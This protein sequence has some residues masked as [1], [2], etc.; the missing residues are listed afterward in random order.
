VR[1]LVDAV[2]S[3]VDCDRV[4]VWVWDEEAGELACRGHSTGE[5]EPL[6]LYAMRFRP[7]DNGQLASLL[8]NP[9]PE[10]LFADR[11]SEDPYATAMLEH[12]ADLTVSRQREHTAEQNV[13]EQQTALWIPHRPLDEAIALR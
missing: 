8:S 2:P 11:E 10:P 13:A 9:T 1:A 4:S 3:V 7:E 6:D 12:R 5:D